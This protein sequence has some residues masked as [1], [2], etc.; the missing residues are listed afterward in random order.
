MRNPLLARSHTPSANISDEDDNATV[1]QLD[2]EDEGRPRPPRRSSPQV[3]MNWMDSV[4]KEM[5][6]LEHPVPSAPPRHSGGREGSPALTEATATTN[7]TSSSSVSTVGIH[8]VRSGRL[9]GAML[10]GGIIPPVRPEGVICD[11]GRRPTQTG[12]ENPYA[13]DGWAL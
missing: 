2:I 13:F 9:I 4:P 12:H 3:I 5:G 6:E 8:P 7:T 10:A 11:W 1:M